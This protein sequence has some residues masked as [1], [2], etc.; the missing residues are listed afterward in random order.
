MRALP[1]SQNPHNTQN[2]QSQA[3]APILSAFGSPGAAK[4][5]PSR[6]HEALLTAFVSGATVAEAARQAGA[7]ERTV[8]RWKSAHWDEVVAARRRVVEGLF[9]RVRNALPIALDRLER[10]AKDSDDDSVAVRASLGLWD[11]FGRVSDRME[12]EERIAALE[13]RAAL[14]RSNG[15]GR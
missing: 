10:I 15:E 6:Y 14:S 7:G 3:S 4:Q 13:K 12:L 5:R 11:I 9:T 8:R 1:L 2:A